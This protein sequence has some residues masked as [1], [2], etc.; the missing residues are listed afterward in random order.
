MLKGQA[1][2]LC[3]RLRV[4]VDQGID[5]D[6]KDIGEAFGVNLRRVLLDSRAAVP[7]IGALLGPKTEQQALD[8]ILIA[9]KEQS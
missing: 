7:G 8:E 9:V 4:S 1:G 5:D 3:E 2:G 6:L